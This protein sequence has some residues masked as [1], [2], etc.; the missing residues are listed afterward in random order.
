MLALFWLA[1][2]PL[3]LSAVLCVCSCVCMICETIC[4]DGEDLDESNV[5]G[6]P[7]LESIRRILTGIKPKEDGDSSEP[8]KEAAVCMLCLDLI[9]DN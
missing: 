7:I 6:P 3:W 9:E 2:A 5:H 1:I 8:P 4:P